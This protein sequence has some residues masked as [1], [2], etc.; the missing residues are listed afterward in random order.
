MKGAKFID[1]PVRKPWARRWLL[2]SVKLALVVGIAGAG[3]DAWFRFSR[4]QES[5]ASMMRTELGYRCAARLS[6]STLLK[7]SANGYAIDISRLGCSSEPFFVLM[8]E[9]RDTRDGKMSFEP[10]GPAFDWRSSTVA[11]F[12]FA[13]MSLIGTSACIMTVA[14]AMW[15]WR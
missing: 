2:R 6:D 1:V 3:Y 14:T 13:L 9:V 12:A 15:I 10:H 4:Y 8:Q 5:R 11:F 7:G